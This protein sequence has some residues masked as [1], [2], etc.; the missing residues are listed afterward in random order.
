MSPREGL[1]ER[2]LNWAFGALG[3]VRSPCAPTDNPS[4]LIPAG[5]QAPDDGGPHDRP[6]YE[7]E[8]ELRVLMSTWM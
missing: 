3:E 4:R 1:R 8:I 5:T 6:D 2:L 7:R